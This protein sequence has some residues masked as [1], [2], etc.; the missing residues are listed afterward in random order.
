MCVREVAGDEHPPE[1][2]F[3]AADTQHASLGRMRLDPNFSLDEV[4]LFH[5]RRI[6]LA[7]LAD[8]LA[9]RLV[10]HFTHPPTYLR[11]LQV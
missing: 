6:A 8:P 3:Q 10:R 4:V 2:N 5:L 1:A 11:L 9:L 7:V